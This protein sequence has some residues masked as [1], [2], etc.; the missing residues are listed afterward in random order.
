MIRFDRR[1]TWLMSALLTVLLI[2]AAGGAA[3]MWLR[4]KRMAHAVD[5][6]HHDKESLETLRHELE[7]RQQTLET[8]YNT[9]TE[10]SKALTQDRDNLRAQLLQAQTSLKGFEEKAGYSQQVQQERDMLETLLKQTAEENRV[11]RNELPDVQ[12]RAEELQQ[13]YQQSAQER[14]RL[15][16]ELA[17]VKDHSREEQLKQ[18]LAAQK[19][20]EKELRNLLKAM[21][22]EVEEIDRR[23]A[24]SRLQLQKLQKDYTSAMDEN[25]KLKNN[26]DRLP[27]DVALM[28]K[29]HQ[30]LLKETADVHY[31]LGVYLTRSKEFERAVT[32]FR[33]VLELRPDDADAHYNLGMI[34]AEHLPNR[35]RAMEHFRRY[36]ALNPNAVDASRVKEYIASWQAWE[37]KER[38][39]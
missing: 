37:A 23:E 16:K 26:V 38:L 29:Q 19:Q 27:G 36:L 39:E 31:N 8:Q 5:Q 14:E 33:K 9:L 11:L 2:A 35:Q 18:E 30:Q 13:S 3:Y 1:G 6:L 24:K 4:A 28:A 32:E 7:I 15:V 22:R 12:K 25:N 20:A 17:E 21:H 10:S 34:Y